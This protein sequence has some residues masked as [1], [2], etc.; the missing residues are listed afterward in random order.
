VA[1]AREGVSGR[2]LTM[3]Y[4]T[5]R[6]RSAA[7]ASEPVGELAN[8]SK[9]HIR[10]ADGRIGAGVGAKFCGLTRGDLSASAHGR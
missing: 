10:R 4:R 2:S 9:A 6:K 7:E 1:T 3:Q 8:G 5:E